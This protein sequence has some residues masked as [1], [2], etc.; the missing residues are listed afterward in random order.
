MVRCRASAWAPP[1]RCGRPRHLARLLGERLEQVD[2]GLGIEAMRLIVCLAEPLAYRQ[3]IASLVADEN[4]DDDIADL[5]DRIENR[6]GRGLVY[7][8]VPVESDVPE[9][10][11]RSI[12][13][14]SPPLPAASAASWPPLL[15]RPVRLFDPPQAVEGAGPAARPP[16]RRLHLAPSPPPGAPRRRPRAHPRRMVAA[17]RRAFRPCA[18]ISRSRTRR[19]GASGCSAA[20]TAWTPPP[21]ICRGSCTGCSERGSPGRRRHFRPWFQQ[22][23]VHPAQQ[24][25]A[26]EQRK[27]A[28]REEQPDP[29]I[30]R[31][32]QDGEI[33]R[34][35]AVAASSAPPSPPHAIPTRR[36]EKPAWSTRSARNS[37]RTRRAAPAPPSR[38]RRAAAAPA[39]PSPRT[40]RTP[41]AIPAPRPPP[42]PAGAAA[43]P[44]RASAAPSTGTAAPPTTS[45][46]R[47]M[48]PPTPIARS[49]PASEN[50]SGGAVSGT[51]SVVARVAT[52][53]RSGS[54]PSSRA[55]AAPEVC[56]QPVAKITTPAAMP[57]SS[58]PGATAG[59]G[60]QR[61][62]QQLKR[63]DGHQPARAAQMR[64]RGRHVDAQQH[65]RHHAHHIGSDEPAH[66]VRQRRDQQ[67]AENAH[68]EQGGA[69][70]G[71]GGEEAQHG[72]HRSVYRP[73]PSFVLSPDPLRRMP[74]CRR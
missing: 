53:V 64:E 1:A 6:L 68:P 60:E 62:D 14:L 41:P 22:P 12:P 40:R 25:R 56:A 61:A 67:A 31:R 23:P 44:P 34:H 48:K 8:S 73:P 51:S 50:A 20:A 70:C 11:V 57:T 16:A 10:S 19:V 52:K 3:S 63:H 9:R 4:P 18:T 66:R 28:D 43:H 17:R 2:P 24:E 47:A 54:S 59:P 38:G 39:R 30:R 49:T 26:E 55:K 15:P 72:V 65:Q 33:Q 21:A 46:S 13:A 69:A 37:P 58:H 7:R 5:V 32:R 27:L 35:V 74:R 29:R 36:P 71:G 42:G 45:T